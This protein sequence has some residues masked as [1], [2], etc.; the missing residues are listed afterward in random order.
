MIAPDL[1]VRLDAL[2]EESIAPAAVGVDADAA[3]PAASI[4]ALR[5]GGWLGL[6]SAPE[7]GGMGGTPLDAARVIERL[8]RACGSTA[9]VT[10]MHYAAAAGQDVPPRKPLRSG[11]FNGALRR[12]VFYC[13]PGW[14]A[15]NHE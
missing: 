3:F 5:A 10:C 15:H 7:V 1:F 8:A 4:E 13:V 2:V 14:P 9:M 6:V 12:V 11:S